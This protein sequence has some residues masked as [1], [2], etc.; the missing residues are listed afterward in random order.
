MELQRSLTECLKRHRKSILSIHA[1]LSITSVLDSISSSPRSNL[2]Q[3]RED[4]KNLFIP[5]EGNYS[6]INGAA[7]FQYELIASVKTYY[8]ENHIEKY[9]KHR[10]RDHV[11]FCSRDVILSEVFQ[12]IV[13]VIFSHL[14][15]F[16]CMHCCVSLFFG[17]FE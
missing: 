14:Q 6:L 4:E 15:S 7:G 3:L 12:L 9:E 13:W 5:E 8:T 11:S 1:G 10:F 2:S 16:Y 17:N